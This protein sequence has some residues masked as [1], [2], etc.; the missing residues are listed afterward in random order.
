MLDQTVQ[1]SD[2]NNLP[3]NQIKK[4]K[5]SRIVNMT[6]NSKQNQKTFNFHKY[7]ETVYPYSFIM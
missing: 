7:I 2:I 6:K 3:L 4:K 1:L 5:K